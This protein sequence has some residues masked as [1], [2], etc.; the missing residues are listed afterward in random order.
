MGLVDDIGGDLLEL[1]TVLAS[2][3]GAEQQLSAGLKLEAEVG[4]GSAT[5]TAV[6]GGQRGTG[7]NSSGHNGLIS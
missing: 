3:V 5:V 2:V 6:L 1:V 4:L 7:G